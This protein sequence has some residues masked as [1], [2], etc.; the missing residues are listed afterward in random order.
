MRAGHLRRADAGRSRRHR[1][2][3]AP[4]A[5]GVR[6]GAARRALEARRARRARRRDQRDRLRPDARHPHADRRDGRGDPRAGRAPATSTS[7]ATSSAR[8]SACSRSAGTGCPARGRRPA[9][10][11]TCGGS[12]VASAR[13]AAR[14]RPIALPGP[15]GETNT[16]EFHPRGVVACIAADDRTLVAQAKAALALGN[17]VLLLRDP[18]RVRV[19]RALDGAAIVLRRQARPAAV[20]AVLLDVDRRS[21]HAA[22]AAM[23]GRGAGPDRARHRSRCR[24]RVRLVAARRRAHG[25]GQHGGGRRQRRAAVARRRRGVT[26]ASAARRSAVP[27]DALLRR[28]RDPRAPAVAADARGARRD[29]ARRTSPRRCARAI[30]STCPASP[31]ASLLLMPAWRTGGADRRQARHGVSGQ[32]AA[33]R[34]RGRR[35][36]RALRRARTARR[37][38]SS[39]ARR[40]RRG[41]PPAR[42]RTPRT[43]SR[44]RTRGTSC[45][46]APAG[47][48]ACWSMR[49]ASCGRS[50]A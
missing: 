41:A 50:S 31:T 38:R 7:T 21:T 33:R 36:V 16:L 24:R 43:G 49:T 25:D 4:C 27:S 18:L 14:P 26:A 34:A 35:R 42:R 9:A 2:A 23:L 8:S 48:R 3:R 15:T 11:S 13:T 1:R 10:R 45:W 5:R 20:D 32:R 19:A 40:S 46:S 39:T 30:R 22:C 17:T 29:A 37:S 12:R 6:A 28:R 47:S 44:A